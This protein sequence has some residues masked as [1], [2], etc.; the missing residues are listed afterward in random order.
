MS[1]RRVHPVFHEGDEVV[2]AEGTYQGTPGVF[3]RLNDDVNWAEITERNGRVCSH[4]VAWLAHAAPGTD[5]RS[6]LRRNW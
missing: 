3:L 6:A 5:Q 1:T 2:L 4:P